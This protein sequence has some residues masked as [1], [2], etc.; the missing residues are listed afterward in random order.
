MGLMAGLLGVGGGVVAV[1]MMTA[2][3]ALTQHQAHGT[4]LAVMI[5]VAVSSLS[6]YILRGDVDWG[7]AASIAG[8]SMVGVVVGARLM[9]RVPARQLRRAFGCFLLIIALRLL[10]GDWWL[11]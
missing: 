6:Q 4:S 10:I 3:L 8:G 5:A 1:P 7:L 9:M 2:F 11:R